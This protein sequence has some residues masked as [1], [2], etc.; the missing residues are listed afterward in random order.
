MSLRDIN[1]YNLIM[2]TKRE[3][4]QN[5]PK[6]TPTKFYPDMVCTGNNHTSKW[7]IKIYTNKCFHEQH[8]TESK[9][10]LLLTSYVNVIVN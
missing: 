9:L 8:A 1:I 3:S 2:W 5:Q 10:Y 6:I 4:Q 7:N